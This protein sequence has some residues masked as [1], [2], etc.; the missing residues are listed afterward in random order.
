M[1]ES[2]PK[3]VLN[4]DRFHEGD[5]AAI[6]ALISAFK[7]GDIPSVKT[8]SN[9]V[10]SLYAIATKCNAR[11]SVVTAME[12][13]RKKLR[14]CMRR[15]FTEP[16]SYR[17]HL[18]GLAALFNH[19]KGAVTLPAHV[20]AFWIEEKNVASRVV[21]R[22]AKNNVVTEKDRKNS[23]TMSDLDKAISKLEEE[24]GQAGAHASLDWLWL[25]QA[26]LMP[27]KRL[28]FGRALIATSRSTA[29]RLLPENDVVVLIPADS[30]RQ[31]EV[32]IR[33][34]KTSG[35]YGLYTETMS[36]EMSD[37]AR[38][39]LVAKPRKYLYMQ[40]THDQPLSSNLFGKW[41][42]E[43]FEKWL[44]KHATMIAVRKAWVREFGDPT[45]FTISER[46]ELARKMNHSLSTQEKSYFKVDRG[47]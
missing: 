46:E 42:T 45:K 18:A 40:K 22:I 47:A 38:K 34:Y 3:R 4:L 29:K 12:S 5:H 27:P 1:P 44:G 30:E 41:V 17:L 26:R 9:A 31:V 37:A 8:L 36:D 2:I 33:N 35:T 6:K 11:K 16:K 39:S 7:H 43:V 24:L 19:A 20:L 23:L 21:T 15:T 10:D 32:W 13:S 25:K 28:D 14:D